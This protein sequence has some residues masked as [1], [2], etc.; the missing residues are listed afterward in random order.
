M[1]TRFQ[2]SFEPLDEFTLDHFRRMITQTRKLGPLN[3][4]PGMGAM[5][6]MMNDVDT[7]GDMRRLCGIIDSM[8]PDERQNPSRI[9]DPGRRRRIAAGAGVDPSEISQLVKSF[10]GMADMMRRMRRREP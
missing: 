9:I 8:T 4:I 3:K 7:E 6:E 5:K 10:D 1:T 2:F